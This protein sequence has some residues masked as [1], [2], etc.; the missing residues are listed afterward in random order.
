VALH[1]LLLLLWLQLLLPY[2]VLLSL[3]LH[4]LPAQAKD[5]AQQLMVTW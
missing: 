4:L 5:L 2:V 1:Q 3:L